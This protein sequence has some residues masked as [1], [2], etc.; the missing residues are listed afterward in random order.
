MDKTPLPFLEQMADNATFAKSDVHPT[1]MDGRI[2]GQR[3]YYYHWRKDNGM[4]ILIFEDPTDESTAKMFRYSRDQ[5]HK[6]VELTRDRSTIVGEEVLRVLH[7][8]QN[9]VAGFYHRVD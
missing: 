5:M 3:P 4:D 1:S 9:S 8:Y 7:G 2:N 6:G